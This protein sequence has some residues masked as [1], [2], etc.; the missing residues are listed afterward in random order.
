LNSFLSLSPFRGII[1]LHNTW[2]YL[3][4]GKKEIDRA[5]RSYTPERDY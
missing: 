1:L 2:L 3:P 4:I 5:I